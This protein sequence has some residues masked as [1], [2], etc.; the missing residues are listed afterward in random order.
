[1]KAFNL[2]EAGAAGAARRQLLGTFLG[3]T[4]VAR[5]TL[6]AVNRKLVAEVDAFMQ[7]Q[8]VSEGVGWGPIQ[9]TVCIE[10]HACMRCSAW[11]VDPSVSF[12]AVC[13]SGGGCFSSMTHAAACAR[14]TA[15]H[16]VQCVCF[17]LSPVQRNY[18]DA[19]DEAALA[20]LLTPIPL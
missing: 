7:H 1:M 9:M 6:E 13:A 19:P 8:G 11:S 4:Q 14:T 16:A 12:L 3:H 20:S 5:D 17:S 18:L 15:S 10:V 2:P